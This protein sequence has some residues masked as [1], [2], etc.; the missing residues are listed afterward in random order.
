VV[1]V[2][3]VDGTGSGTGVTTEVVDTTPS[4]IFNGFMQEMQQIPIITKMPIIIY[5]VFL[6]IY[7][8]VCK[9]I[10]LC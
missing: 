2:V 10:Q 5:M 4:I 9:N 6:F 8:I 3:V 7:I 1:V